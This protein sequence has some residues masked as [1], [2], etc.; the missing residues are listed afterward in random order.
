MW[1]AEVLNPS[2]SRPTLPLKLQ[3]RLLPC[4][5]QLQQVPG[6]PLFAATKLQSL[7]PSLRSLLLCMSKCLR[8][9]L[10]RTPDTGFS[11]QQDFPRQSHLKIFNLITYA[12]LGFYRSHSRL[13]VGVEGWAG[14]GLIF[15]QT[16]FNPLQLVLPETVWLHFHFPRPGLKRRKPN[17][18]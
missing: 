17:I 12:N 1:K 18:S 7:P 10:S 6:T 8:F 13:G 11:T 2:V 3:G 15:W 9:S 16:L 14:H 5:F 4:L